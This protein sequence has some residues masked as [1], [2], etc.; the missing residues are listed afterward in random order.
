MHSSKAT[1]SN[2]QQ[3]MSFYFLAAISAKKEDF[4]QALEFVEKGLVKNCHNVK[5]RGL[6]A[7]ILRKL[8]KIEEAKQWIKENFKIDPFD[9][10]YPVMKQFF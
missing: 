3:E 10:I 4:L 1:W 9:Y 5:A 8:G 7:T 6:K 2:E